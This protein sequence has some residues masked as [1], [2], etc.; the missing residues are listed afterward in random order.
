MATTKHKRMMDFSKSIHAVL[1]QVHPSYKITEQ[2]VS[3]LNAFLNATLDRI[4]SEAGRL[5]VLEGTEDEEDEI[6]HQEISEAVQMMFTT[7]LAKYAILDGNK[8][9]LKYNRCFTEE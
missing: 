1:L 4:M 8:A 9:L 2:S 6:T 5:A 7:A 3:T